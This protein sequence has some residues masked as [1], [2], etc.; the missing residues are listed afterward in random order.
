MQLFCVERMP[1]YVDESGISGVRR[2]SV[3]SKSDTVGAG[4][5][6]ES[7]VSLSSDYPAGR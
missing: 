5:Q 7:P 6:E 3:R 2:V 1:D 4:G